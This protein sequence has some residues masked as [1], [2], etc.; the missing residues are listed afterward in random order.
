MQVQKALQDGYDVRTFLY[1]T[2]VDNFE[3]QGAQ[4]VPQFLTILK[5]D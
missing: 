3:W 4:I 1:W 5:H 2:L